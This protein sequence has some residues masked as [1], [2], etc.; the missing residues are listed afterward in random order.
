MYYLLVHV[1]VGT[2]GMECIH[3][4]LSNDQE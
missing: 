4:I 1:H 3:C 2:V